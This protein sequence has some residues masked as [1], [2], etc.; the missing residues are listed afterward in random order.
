M[1]CNAHF[2][3]WFVTQEDAQAHP[4]VAQPRHP[5]LEKPPEL[6]TTYQIASMS[7]P[8]LGREDQEHKAPPSKPFTTLFTK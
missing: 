8:L 7:F 3:M 6:Q 5:W 1:G 2:G 4:C